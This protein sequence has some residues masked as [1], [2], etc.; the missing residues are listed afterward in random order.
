MK[1]LFVE[2]EVRS[3]AIINRTRRISVYL[4]E[5]ELGL[6]QELVDEMSEMSE[7]QLQDY[8]NYRLYDKDLAWYA[9]GDPLQDEL[10]N[11]V[12]EYDEDEYDRVEEVELL[13]VS[14]VEDEDE[15]DD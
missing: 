11:S 3:R 1:D 9:H 10:I 8:L 6:P 12:P 2:I 4:G 14:L 15:E 5:G 7:E 13:S